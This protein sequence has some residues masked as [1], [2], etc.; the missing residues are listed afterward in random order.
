MSGYTDDVLVRAGA[1]GAP[2][3]D[4]PFTSATLSATVASALRA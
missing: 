2:V 1:E 3:L 4:K